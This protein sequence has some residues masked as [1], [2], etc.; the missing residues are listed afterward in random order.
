M[1]SASLISKPV[2]RRPQ[3]D[4]RRNSKPKCWLTA[5]STHWHWSASGRCFREGRL[6]N[7]IAA[8]QAKIEWVPNALSSSRCLRKNN[9]WAGIFQDFRQ[10]W[11]RSLSDLPRTSAENDFLAGI[12]RYF[13]Q[14]W[15]NSFPKS[16]KIPSQISFPSPARFKSDRLLDKADFGILIGTIVYGMR[17]STP[18][19]FLLQTGLG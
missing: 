15:P 8:M 10:L 9:F 2:R 3:T 19:D 4:A 5:T 14:L 7:R 13:R 6:D 18:R 16:R 12:S 1:Q 11:P 17:V